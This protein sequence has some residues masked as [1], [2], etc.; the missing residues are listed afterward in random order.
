M[1]FADEKVFSTLSPTTPTMLQMESLALRISDLEE[2]QSQ[3]E[4]L[5]LLLLACSAFSFN[6]SKKR[7]V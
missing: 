6:C 5:L 1:Q 7:N 3:S 2:S 4:L